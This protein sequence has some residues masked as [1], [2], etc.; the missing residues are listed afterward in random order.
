MWRC[1]AISVSGHPGS[2]WGDVA[3]ALENDLYSLRSVISGELAV[4]VRSG[5]L[6]LFFNTE[7]L[8]WRV[9]EWRARG[10]NKQ[11]DRP[12][13][14]RNSLLCCLHISSSASSNWK[15]RDCS[16]WL[17]ALQTH[18]W[19]ND[20]DTTCFLKPGSQGKLNPIKTS[21]DYPH[22]PTRTQDLE[23]PRLQCSGIE[24]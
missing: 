23:F 17:G 13:R 22:P 11:A 14:Q 19:S 2:L 3:P 12:V 16:A 5:I 6:S 18:A 24:G 7:A 1:S 10:D 9:N 15:R 21:C 20:S 4:H 8:V